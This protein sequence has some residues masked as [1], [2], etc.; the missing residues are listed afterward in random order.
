MQYLVRV[1]DLGPA[2]IYATAVT[3]SLS[4]LVVNVRHVADETAAWVR[5]VME[6]AEA[7]QPAAEA[8]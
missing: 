3:S 5:Q 4:L 8:D 1:A 2:V 7:E 6:S